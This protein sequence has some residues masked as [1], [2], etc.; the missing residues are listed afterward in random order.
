MP[1]T[2]KIISSGYRLSEPNIRR[3]DGNW[4]NQRRKITAIFLELGWLELEY[5]EKKSIERERPQYIMYKGKVEMVYEKGKYI[6][7]YLTSEQLGNTLSTTTPT[8]IYIKDGIFI[9]GNHLGQSIKT[10]WDNYPRYIYGLLSRV[11]LYS[12]DE[13]VLEKCVQE[14]FLID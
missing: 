1:T 6:E 5:I 12:E 8:K 11:S 9:I 13:R 7:H 3:K 14:G 4:S 10:V 2:S